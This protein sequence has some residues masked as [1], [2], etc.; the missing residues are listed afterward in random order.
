MLEAFPYEEE[1]VEIHPGDLLVMY[2][3]GI[4]EAM[5]PADDQFGREH[6]ADLLREGRQLPLDGLT[7]KVVDAVKAHAGN[8]PQS[9]DITLVA[10]RRADGKEPVHRS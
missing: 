4:T 10:I 9:D 1:E 5:N 6:L 3:D 2:S 8:A 7:A